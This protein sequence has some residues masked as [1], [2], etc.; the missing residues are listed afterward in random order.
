M[1]DHGGDI[2]G[3]LGWSRSVLPIGPGMRLEIEA[4]PLER[5][6]SALRRLDVAD[7]RLAGAAIFSGIESDFLAFDQPTHPGAL[8]RRGMDE[9]ILAAIVRLNKAETLLVV[10]EFH[11]TCIHRNILSLIRCT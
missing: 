1:I 11:G 4:A 7:G 2:V 9:N 5:L 3:P 8:K 6:R 10:V